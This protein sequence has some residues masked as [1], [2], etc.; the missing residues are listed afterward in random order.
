M[1]PKTSSMNR[2]YEAMKNAN[3]TEKKLLTQ[4]LIFSSLVYFDDDYIKDEL[5]TLNITYKILSYKGMKCLVGEVDDIIFISFRGTDASLWVNWKRDFNIIPRDFGRGF[6]VHGGFK[7][8]HDEYKSFVEDYI[9]SINKDKKIIFTGH[10]LGGAVAALYN[11]SYNKRSASITFG[12]PN[13]IFNSN[14]NELTSSSYSIMSDIVPHLPFSLPFMRW[15]KA[16]HSRKLI[17]MTKF[18]NPFSYHR[19]DNY[20]TSILSQIVNLP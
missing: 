3:T 18:L 15:T 20:I 17:A 4:A 2:L 11:I 5:T 1:I 8:Y 6:K 19:L 12:S 14:Y 13:Y 10:S 16:C 7:I 9:N